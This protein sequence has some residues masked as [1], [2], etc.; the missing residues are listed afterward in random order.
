MNSVKLV[1]GTNP[2]YD[3]S[4][5]III[6]GILGTGITGEIRE[7]YASAMKF[8]NNSEAFKLAVDVPSG[9]NPDSGETS[10]SLSK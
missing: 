4:C 1:Y 3:I 2:S 10:I 8:I 6:D 9:V 5:D 7:P